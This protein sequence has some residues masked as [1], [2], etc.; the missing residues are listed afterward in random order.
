[1]N[2]FKKIKHI[3]E[4]IKIQPDEPFNFLPEE[5]SADWINRNNMSHLSG[6]PLKWANVSYNT[7]INIAHMSKYLWAIFGVF[8]FE[9]SL[10]ISIPLFVTAISSH[11]LGQWYEYKQ[12]TISKIIYSHQNLCSFKD[13]KIITN[14]NCKEY[15]ED[16]DIFNRNF[17]GDNNIY[18]LVEFSELDVDR[19]NYC[20]NNILFKLENID[21]CKII[22]IVNKD[23]VWDISNA[24]A[25]RYLILHESK[26]TSDKKSIHDNILVLKVIKVLKV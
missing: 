8:T 9:N 5:K 14:E 24:G 3:G 16:L 20:G 25:G 12:V 19:V 4:N 2:K 22:F 7:K 1:L 17:V 23:T 13:M 11:F 21:G 15:F 26:N 18:T 6:Y 10:S